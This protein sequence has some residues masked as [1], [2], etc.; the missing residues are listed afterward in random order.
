MELTNHASGHAISMGFKEKGKMIKTIHADEAKLAELVTPEA[1]NRWKPIAHK[2]IPAIITEMVETRGWSFIDM[3]GKRF[4]IVITEDGAKLFGVCLLKI[5]GIEESSEFQIAVGFRN[6][7]DKVYAFRMAVGSNVTVCSN[8]MITGDLQVNRV[9]TARIN[10]PDVVNEVFNMIP[11]AAGHIST[12]MN[13]LQQLPCNSDQG[14]ALLAEAVDKDALPIHSF[15]DAR[16]EYLAAYRNENPQIQHGQTI[17]AMYQAVTA[18]W[19]KR[20]LSNTQIYSGRLNQM[21]TD[22]TGLKLIA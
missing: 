16:R 8:K 14:I 13:N 19:K 11:Q 5:P 21:I 20:I 4:D 3:G 17:W 6:S 18:Q 12:W 1:T 15:M 10:A 22:K 2:D 9:H 7:V